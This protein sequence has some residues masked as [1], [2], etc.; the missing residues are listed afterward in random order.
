MPSRRAVYGRWPWNT[1]MQT[2]PQLLD[3]E[4]PKPKPVL[5]TQ[6]QK[7]RTVVTKMG[8]SIVNA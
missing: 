7:P 2:N 5:E 3:F 8:V 6:R 1:L 4:K